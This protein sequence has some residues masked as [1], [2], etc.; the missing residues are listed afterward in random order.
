LRSQIPGFE[1]QLQTGRDAYAQPL[2]PQNEDDSYE[3]GY[4]KLK[5]LSA[6]RRD[7]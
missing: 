2:T 1:Y 4:G 3:W 6:L 7:G 5:M